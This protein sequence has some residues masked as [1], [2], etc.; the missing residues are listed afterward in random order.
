MRQKPWIGLKPL[1]IKVYKEQVKI[2]VPGSTHPHKLLEE[3]RSERGL[4]GKRTAK[5]TLPR[6]EEV[7]LTAWTASPLRA[8]KR[9]YFV[10]IWCPSSEQCLKRA[11]EAQLRWAGE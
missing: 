2:R 9:V 7:A 11:A 5:E 8:I 6:R 10:A 4:S 3:E 1:Y